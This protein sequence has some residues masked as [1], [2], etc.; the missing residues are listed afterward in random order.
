MASSA[1]HARTVEA[2]EKA[3][4][5]VSLNAAEPGSTEELT[6]CMHAGGDGRDVWF[7]KSFNL[8]VYANGR[9]GEPH[10]AVSMV[11]AS[12]AWRARVRPIRRASPT[13]SRGARPRRV[14]QSTLSS[15][16]RIGHISPTVAGHTPRVTHATLVP[17]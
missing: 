14:T 2:V 13:A 15:R 16:A 10:L 3:L 1:E 4:F 5:T 8:M 11:T 17:L 6:K 7:D 9:A 12:A